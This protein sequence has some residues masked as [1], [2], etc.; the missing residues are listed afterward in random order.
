MPRHRPTR[1]RRDG[2]LVVTGIAWQWDEEAGTWNRF[3]IRRYRR[4]G[5]IDVTALV[6]V[7]EHRDF[8]LACLS[9]AIQYSAP[10][11]G[12]FQT[13]CRECGARYHTIK[14]PPGSSKP[15]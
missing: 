11:H 13:E 7:D 8:C 5:D 10:A 3:L 12:L 15:E 6:R 9:M 2:P 4:T 1:V 14:P